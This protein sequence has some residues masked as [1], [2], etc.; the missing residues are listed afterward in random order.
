[1]QLEIGEAVLLDADNVSMKNLKVQTFTDAGKPDF[2]IDLPASTMNLATD[3]LTSEAPVEVR[4]REFVLRGDSIRFDTREKKGEL[5]GRVRMEIFGSI[6]E[7]MGSIEDPK[8]K[9][10]KKP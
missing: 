3:L 2:L 1:M 5:H 7:P 6:L 9:L 4:T 8:V 10:K